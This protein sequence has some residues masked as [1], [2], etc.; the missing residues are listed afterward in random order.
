[1][2]K[3]SKRLS[4]RQFNVAVC[5]AAT[6]A[7]PYHAISA[8]TANRMSVAA[9][10]MHAVLG[11]VDANL[12]KATQLV[13]KA[14]SKGAQTVVL[15]EFFTSGL[16]YHPCM[17]HAHRPIDGEPMQMLKRLSKEH[18]IWLGGSFLA[19]SDG[20][21]YNTFALAIPDGRVFTHDKDFP[22]GAIEQMLYAA[23]ED[24][25]F[26]RMLRNPTRTDVI[27]SRQNNNVP[28]VFRIGASR[29]G[30]AMCWELVRKRTDRRLLKAKPD[31]VLAGS[32]WYCPEPETLAEILGGS[33]EHWENVEQ[34][35]HREVI[36]APVRLAIMVGAP[37]VHA[38]LVGASE[39][40]RFPTGKGTIVRNFYGESQ[41]VDASGN[42]IARRAKHDGEGIV[43]GEVLASHREPTEEI[44]DGFWHITRDDN[45]AWDW[46]YDA[47]G[48]DYYLSVTQP[49]RRLYAD[50]QRTPGE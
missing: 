10:Q 9:V 39:S 32:G 48:R 28:G 4:R 14:V 37:V 24:A 50:S 11:D 7:I 42:V 20:H 2:S 21:V 15:P 25:E 44:G 47:Y 40:Y 35:N 19:E 41:V 17:M 3:P 34:Q 8:A 27:P 12:N 45:A 46:W 26:V 16:G 31:I 13:E 29:I 23:G 6:A 49:Q 1:M 30:N 5:G 38:N 18:G 43:I 22:T 33:I 36:E